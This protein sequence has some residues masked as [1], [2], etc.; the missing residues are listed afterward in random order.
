MPALATLEELSQIYKKLNEFKKKHPQA[1]E[2][3]TLLLK[4]HRKI[5]YKNIC[6]MYIGE[7]TPENLKE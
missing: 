6:K 1:S 7:A 3:L 2:D 5:G 4:S